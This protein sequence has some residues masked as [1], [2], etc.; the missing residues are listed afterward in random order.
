MVHNMF[1][2]KPKSKNKEKNGEIEEDLNNYIETHEDVT[3]FESFIKRNKLIKSYQYLQNYFKDDNSILDE[4]SNFYN[5]CKNIQDRKCII[6]IHSFGQSGNFAES[7]CMKILKTI[8]SKLFFKIISDT[9]V[10]VGNVK[11]IMKDTHRSTEDI[12]KNS[13]LKI[14]ELDAFTEASFSQLENFENYIKDLPEP[15]ICIF[16][17]VHDYKLDAV[18]S[19]INIFADFS[20]NFN[21]EIT[22]KEYENAINDYFRLKNMELEI[23]WEKYLQTYIQKTK[24]SK[25]VDVF[26][27]LTDKLE[28]EYKI[29][30]KV[31]NVI[32]NKFF[33][34]KVFGIDAS[35]NELKG[36]LKLEKLIGM[37]EVKDKVNQLIAYLDFNEKLRQKIGKGYPVNL[38]M[39]FTGS[40][41]TGKTTIARI[42]AEILFELGYIEK[43]KLIEVDK[44]D[45]V[46]QWVGHTSIK[47]NEVIQRAMGGVL[48]VDEAY[49]VADDRFGKDAIATLIKA[50]EDYKTNLVVI[51]AGYEKEMD[52]FIKSNPGI[53]SR[54]GH[55]VN[56]QDYSTDELLMIY[57]NKLNE[58][59]IKSE[60]SAVL[61]LTK[62]IEKCKKEEDFG[63]GRF[64]DNLIQDILF[65]HA[66][67]IQ[68]TSPDEDILII[69]NEDIP[70]KYKTF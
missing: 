5:Y 11:N 38:H 54:I 19:K 4:I 37:Q 10:Y 23:G 66:V 32:Q 34:V 29:S 53:K 60:D 43:N 39:C 20:F 24:N 28:N 62:I 42:I 45:L 31:N 67:N 47:T 68:N 30:G 14:G 63:N 25:D 52:D 3:S 7:Y 35:M 48:F 41:G 55:K 2:F 36:I 69:K 27:R 21:K 16:H 15:M 9:P 17:N 50:M 26:T 59:Q 49:S 58:Y 65:K 40:P 46:S 18:F 12:L 13:F 61:L 22:T 1:S 51:F 56:F 8:A 70:D 6:R 44:K 64:I 57:K 33:G